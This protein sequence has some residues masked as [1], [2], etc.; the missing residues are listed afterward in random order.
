M[1]S[2]NLEV[3][4]ELFPHSN[5]EEERNG[6]WV[7][8]PW[9]RAVIRSD[10]AF[11]EM[12]EVYDHPKDL[13]MYEGPLKYQRWQVGAQWSFSGEGWQES[14]IDKVVNVEGASSLFIVDQTRLG[15]VDMKRAHYVTRP[16]DIKRYGL[17]NRFNEVWRAWEGQFLLCSREFHRRYLY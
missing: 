6:I 12:F 16:T 8:A 3:A 11:M 10:D 5:I 14:L 2:I 13:A 9:C 7:K 1:T 4:G 17:D 15:S